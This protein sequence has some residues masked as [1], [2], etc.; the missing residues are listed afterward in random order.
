MA[1]ELI[2]ILPQRALSLPGGLTGIIRGDATAV[3]A[4]APGWSERLRAATKPGGAA[5]AAQRHLTRLEALLALGPVLP[6]PAGTACTA[7]EAALLLALDAPL[8]ARLAHEIGPRR[9]YQL[10]LDWD[11]PQVLGAFRTS[12]ELAPLFTGAPLTP[13]ALRDGVAALADRLRATA[14]RLLAPAIEDPLDQ[15][16]GADSLLNLVFLLPPEA[17]PRLE[18]ALEAIDALWTEGLRL[19][20]VGPSAPFSHAL[21]EIDRADAAA[22]KRAADLLGLA[23]GATP[24]TIAETAKAALRRLDLP[25]N[26]AEAIRVA[27]QTLIR[28]QQAAGLGLAPGAA[29]PRVVHLRPG[30]SAVP[31]PQGRAA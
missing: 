26:G 21:I 22:L 3:L 10:T 12:P 9:H 19:R 30:T 8:I 20:L 4:E 7:E 24:E 17:E 15:P 2:A 1:H 13:E 28:V 29:L 31:H 11:A 18:A 23:P 25:A 27:A 14:M 16:R 5:Q 6:C